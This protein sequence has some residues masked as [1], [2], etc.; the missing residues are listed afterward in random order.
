MD[1]RKFIINGIGAGL[2][3]SVAKF[4]IFYI[5]KALGFSA[6]PVRPLPWDLIAVRGGEPDAMFDQAID[7]QGGIQQ[8]VKK[9]NT[10]VVKP[11]IGWDSMPERAG[12]TNPR[13][14]GR[15]VKRCLEAGAKD[16]YVFDHTCDNWS[17]C[18]ANSGI[19]KAVKDAGGKIVG[20][21]TENYYQ[22]VTLNGTSVLKSVKV[23]ELIIHS[24]VFFNVPVLKQHTS[25]KVTV[26]LKN[27]MGIVWDR[28]FWHKNNLQ[29]CIAEFPLW[30][31]PTLNIVDA[32]NV[33]M[34]NGPRGV[35][36][37]DI[38][39]MKTLILSTD[40]VAADAAAIKFFGKEPSEIAYL[41]IA[42]D[43]KIGN[44]NLDQLKINRLKA[45]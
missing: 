45:V 1:R 35:S 6:L 15:I 9:G 32:Y 12:D 13:L 28:E 27:L 37:S 41:R 21:N 38:S 4:G 33:I 2:A 23:H 39:P 29:Q 31:K 11:N 40:I 44:M 43:L 8:F 24:D 25:C 22:E 16:V 36:S 7:S 10:V 18:Y 14:I 17:R 20:G 42:H 5:N 34:R 19:E 30:K 26:S 3:A